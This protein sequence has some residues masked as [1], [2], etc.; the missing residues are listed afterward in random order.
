M[1][2]WDDKKTQW[3]LDSMSS[4]CEW[5]ALNL[6]NSVSDFSCDSSALQEAKLE[7]Q[8]WA[9]TA[10]G[11]FEMGSLSPFEYQCLFFFLS[12]VVLS[13]FFNS[14][15]MHCLLIEAGYINHSFISLWS[16]TREIHGPVKFNSYWWEIKTLW[17]TLSELWL[18]P[19]ILTGYRL[20]CP[21]I[22]TLVR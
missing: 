2:K 19:G 6:S 14:F 21:S 1:Y 11:A 17:A 5:K 3:A 9:S 18:L 15:L 12:I 8:F 13:G 7:S 16:T 20:S 10:L 4:Q 22:W